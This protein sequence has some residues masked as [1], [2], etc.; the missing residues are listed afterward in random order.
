MAKTIWIRTGCRALGP[1][2]I[3]GS[4]QRDRVPCHACVGRRVPARLCDV[5]RECADGS[6]YVT[7]G[8]D[9]TPQAAGQRAKRTGGRVVYLYGKNL[10]DRQYFI[11]EFGSLLRIA[12]LL[13]P[14]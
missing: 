10:R 9:L 8:S 5:V 11:A 14:L 2:T 7:L 4:W 12:K 3:C 13:G 1:G 6:G